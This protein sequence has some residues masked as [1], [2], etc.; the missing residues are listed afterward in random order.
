MAKALSKSI[1]SAAAVDYIPPSMGAIATMQPI[2][3]VGYDTSK[4]VVTDEREF[5]IEDARRIRKDPTVHLARLLSVAPILAASWSVE[6]DDD[7]SPAAIDFVS[8]F[9]KFRSFIVKEAAFGMMD[10]G[11]RGMEAVWRMEKGYL[12]IDD[13]ISL[14]PDI[15]QVMPDNVGSFLGFKQ[16]FDDYSG[17]HHEQVIQG[18]VKAVL[19][20]QRQEGT[21]YYGQSD[22]EIIEDTKNRYDFANQIAEQYDTKSAGAVWVIQY[23]VG[24]TLLNGVM[25]ENSDIAR[26]LLASIKSNGGI[27]IPTAVQG[28]IGNLVQGATANSLAN[29]N[30]WQIKLME[31]TGSSSAHLLS[32]MQ[33]LE[34]LM[35]RGI[36]LPERSLL[37][38]K[39]GTKAEAKV[40]TDVALTSAIDRSDYII[41][42][43]NEGPVNAG[44]VIN[45][46]PEQ[47]GKV[48][49]IA[50]P[51]G[52]DEKA[53]LREVYMQILSTADVALLDLEN[54]DMA[55]VREIT[56][57]PSVTQDALQER[58]L[59]KF[60]S[61]LSN[62]G[63][64]DV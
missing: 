25:T 20:N 24:K 28:A 53:F 58:R 35:V 31:S 15:T 52:D 18:K 36:G 42:K 64:D 29:P 32:R 54:I 60:R 21:N 4:N 45:F 9:R 62:V 47:E 63:G 57:V 13:F 19:F 1:P 30:G 26:S 41:G 61:D 56:G 23:P 27:T 37:E 39:H 51:I 44:L 3:L 16:I 55:T 17:R 50:E 33:H 46:G 8:K 40:H 14:L 10:Y 43:L 34:T 12:E 2:D 59:D 49:L 6:N 5:S 38:G 22:L 7:A 11:W 48:R